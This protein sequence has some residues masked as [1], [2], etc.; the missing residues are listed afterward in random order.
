MYIVIRPSQNKTAVAA[1]L[2]LD[3]FPEKNKI[4][5]KMCSSVRNGGNWRKVT[6]EGFV[7]SKN[8]AY[9]KIA[10]LNSL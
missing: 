10:Y 6:N 1:R 5:K 7:S 4:K 9:E 2:Q 8:V 3:D